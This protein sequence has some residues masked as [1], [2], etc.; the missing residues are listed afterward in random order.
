MTGLPAL[1]PAQANAPYR[2]ITPT[3]A[4]DYLDPSG[5]GG[6]GTAFVNGFRELFGLQPLAGA[7]LIKA[8]KAGR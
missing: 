6:Y 1:P 4:V 7:E 5:D 8:A 2:D 3:S